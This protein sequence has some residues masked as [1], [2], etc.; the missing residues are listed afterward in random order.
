[1]GF[2]TKKELKMSLLG[3]FNYGGTK[4]LVELRAHMIDGGKSLFT[5]I[6]KIVF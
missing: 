3:H 5:G 4:S 6:E 2:C 1:M